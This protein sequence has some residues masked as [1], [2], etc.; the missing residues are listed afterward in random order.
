[1]EIK[2]FDTNLQLKG[3][4]DTPRFL[5]FQRKLFG[6]GVFKIQLDRRINFA[7]ELQI[8]RI[9]TVNNSAGIIEEVRYTDDV[10]TVSGYE[11]KGIQKRRVTKPASGQ[12][13]VKY[14]STAIET[15]LKGIAATDF[16][17]LEIVTD[18]ATGNTVSISSRY[19]NVADE[20]EEV[21]RLGEM[22]YYIYLDTVAGKFKF[23]IIQVVDK[24]STSLNPV[25]FSKHYDNIKTQ[26]YLQSNFN[27]SNYAIVA[28]QGE[29]A[30][31]TIEEVGT[32]T[33][34][35]KREVFID[36]RDIDT[37][38]EL[39][40]R[41]ESK[42]AELEAVES[43]NCQIINKTFLYR[44]DWDLGSKITIQDKILNIQQDKIIESVTEYY[45]SVNNGT[46]V[47]DFGNSKA[48]IL[49]IVKNKSNIGV[50]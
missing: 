7:S 14:T 16:D 34:Y 3:I 26:D 17:N 5:Q 50:I 47:V 25:I 43:F 48:T 15:V 6:V 33:S 35:S 13:H 22:G 24:T 9:I 31:R 39:I 4:I 40:A 49:D 28:G 44:V 20:L 18:G 42:L 27:S 11:L 29:G 30:L 36:A 10:M 41:G 1:M 12:S 8:D 19:K 23:D 21:G 46:I 38:A 2:I 37:T 45:D 32:A